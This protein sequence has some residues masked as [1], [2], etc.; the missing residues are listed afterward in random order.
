MSAPRTPHADGSTVWLRRFARTTPGVIGMVAVVVATMSVITGLVCGGQLDRRIAERDAV[1][2]RSEPFTYSAQNLYAALSAAD[3]AAASE[4]L[5]G[6]ETAPVRARYREALLDA[7]AALADA[8]A[9]STDSDARF[10]VADITARLAVYTGLIESARANNLQGHVIGSAYLREASALMQMTLLPSA[11][12]I[13]A[14]NLAIV[15]RNQG[16]VS[17]VPAVGFA[18]LA[19]TFAAIV[20]GSVIVSGRTNRQF[21]VGLI[22]AATLVVVV[23][24]W[25]ATATRLAA[26]DIDDARIEGAVKFRQYA[27]ARIIAQ[28]ARTDETLALIAHGDPSA[29]EESFNGRIEDL[30]ALL[31]TA[32][33]A[34]RYV[35]AWAEGHRVQVQAYNRGDY[36]AAVRQAIGAEPDG[37]AA[38]F[39]AVESTLRTEIERSH[40]TLRD[41]VSA[42]GAWLSWSPTGTLALM[43]SAAV[44]AVAGLWPRFQ[45]FQ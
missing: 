7:A 36:S 1:L 29:S 30:R 41:R 9:G 16:S 42:A 38:R 8:T 26:A 35:D 24:G 5:S 34:V 13:Y 32:P 21:N 43:V 15:D 18:L 11:E 28:Q 3:A 31:A 19:I 20:G 44:A 2:E 39:T 22:V 10:A 23:G 25:M 4:Y 6:K 40:N 17:S 27:Q 14:R 33:E 45:E 37:S 12:K